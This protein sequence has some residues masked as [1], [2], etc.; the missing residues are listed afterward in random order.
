MNQT[1]YRIPLQYPVAEQRGEP[2]K[3][4]ATYKVLHNIRQHLYISANMAYLHY[5]QL[6]IDKKDETLNKLFTEFATYLQK[7]QETWEALNNAK[8]NYF[9][10][11]AT[12]ETR[13][14]DALKIENLPD[15]LKEMRN[16]A[17]R[18]IYGFAAADNYVTTLK[19]QFA[20]YI[21]PIVLEYGM[22]KVLQELFTDR[23][24]ADPEKAPPRPRVYGKD[25]PIFFKWHELLKDN[26]SQAQENMPTTEEK[27]VRRYNFQW[28]AHK[29]VLLVCRIGKHQT[30]LAKIFEEIVNGK[31]RHKDVGDPCLLYAGKDSWVLQLVHKM[32]RAIPLPTVQEQQPAI[33]G[34]DLG[35]K[36]PIAAGIIL[37]NGETIKDI[38]IGLTEDG[39]KDQIKEERKKITAT[40]A[41][42]IAAQRQTRSGQ[43]RGRKSAILKAQGRAEKKFFRALNAKWA[44]ELVNKAKEYGVGII[45][46]EDL[47]F[48]ETRKRI[49]TTAKKIN[50]GLSER[51]VQKVRPSWSDYL[52]TMYRHWSYGHLV[53]CIEKEATDNHILVARVHPAKTSKQCWKCMSAT[54]EREKQADLC[55]DADTINNCA[56]KNN[57]CPVLKKT[58]TTKKREKF[59]VYYLP[60]DHNAALRIAK[61]QQYHTKNDVKI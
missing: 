57:G 32:E 39:K 14:S 48:D 9:K 19:K 55:F 10:G 12:A 34:V 8:I 25:F 38:S 29:D 22:A 43:G 7:E 59:V 53:A 16:T 21:P 54:G 46:I 35:Y 42:K 20:P 6:L 51:Q 11:S 31:V 52:L 27:T 17:K 4:S 47:N 49:K 44:N 24:N 45:K 58:K 33:M 56:Y 13:E 1:S 60:A 15:E 30:E 41:K 61:A 26:F 5:Y 18:S 37:P 3:N 50:E 40:Y 2:S 23:H 36:I 28:P